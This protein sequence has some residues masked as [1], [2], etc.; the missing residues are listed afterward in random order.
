LYADLAALYGFPVRYTTRRDVTC[1]AAQQAAVLPLPKL[2]RVA[3]ILATERWVVIMA[4]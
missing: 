2:V 1:G 3:F 4:N